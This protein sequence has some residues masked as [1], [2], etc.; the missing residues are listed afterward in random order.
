MNPKKDPST[1][2]SNRE[3]EIVVVDD[4]NS[5]FNETRQPARE[6]VRKAVRERLEK[7]KKLLE[8]REAMYEKT[9]DGQNGKQ[10]ANDVNRI[11]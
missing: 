9:A 3:V 8:L 1:F 10:A 4:S 6:F 11:E 2:G 7:E 5:V